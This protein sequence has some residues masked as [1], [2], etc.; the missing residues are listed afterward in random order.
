MM[1]K[2]MAARFHGMGG[3]SAEPVRRR[4]FDRRCPFLEG[5][6]LGVGSDMQVYDV[7]ENALAKLIYVPPAR[8]FA[9]IRR[10]RAPGCRRG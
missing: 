5:L 1:A 6:G 8:G 2:A 7:F 10:G 4:I 3:G 9:A